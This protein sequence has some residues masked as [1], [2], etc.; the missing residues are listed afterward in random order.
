M[1][2]TILI[3]LTSFFLVNFTGKA[4]AQ[5]EDELIEICGMIAKEA[6]YLKDF[7][8]RLDAGDP[9][10]TQRFSVILKKDIKYRFSVCNS[11]DFEGK[12]VLQLFDNNRLLATTH[13]IATGKDYPSIDFNCQK[14]GAYHLFFQFKDGKAGLAVGLLSLV[15]TL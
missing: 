11:K 9:P 12:V 3:L 6:T 8:I 13:V 1:R 2:N 14:T 5:T 15:E 7:K 10:P 4:F